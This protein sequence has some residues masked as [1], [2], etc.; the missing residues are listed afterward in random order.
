MV[1]NMNIGSI[2]SVIK[3]EISSDQINL[4]NESVLTNNMKLLIQENGNTILHI[5]ELIKNI[6]IHEFERLKNSPNSE[7]TDLFKKINLFPSLKLIFAFLDIPNIIFKVARED[8]Q[9]EELKERHMDVLKYKE[10]CET[11][12]WDK[13]II[14]P[15]ILLDNLCGQEAQIYA[16]IRLDVEVD[17]DKQLEIFRFRSSNKEMKKAMRQLVFFIGRTDYSDTQESNNPPLKNSNAFALIDL[18]RKGMKGYVAGWKSLISNI[19]PEYFNV[20][21]KSIKIFLSSHNKDYEET[22][23][24][25]KF[26]KRLF[27]LT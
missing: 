2:T 13:L 7:N 5:I 17:G 3:Y 12:K 14:P 11:E 10:I 19:T 4:T 21:R 24:E 22:G 6:S 27:Q 18:E 9:W 26:K 8:Y 20:V 1:A 16:E 25:E 15:S 23:I